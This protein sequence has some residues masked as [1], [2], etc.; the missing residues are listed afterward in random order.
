MST[1]SRVRVIRI[2]VRTRIIERILL[3]TIIVI[4]RYYYYLFISLENI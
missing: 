2:I 4:Y 3:E 1:T